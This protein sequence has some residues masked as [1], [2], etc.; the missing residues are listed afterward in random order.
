L[1]L[2]TAD[3]TMDAVPEA[4]KFWSGRVLKAWFAADPQAPGAS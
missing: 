3:A 1:Y 2:P 4:H